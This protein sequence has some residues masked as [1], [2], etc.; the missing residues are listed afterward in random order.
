MLNKGIENVIIINTNLG[1]LPNKKRENFW[2]L[3]I[4]FI[5]SYIIIFINLLAFLLLLLFVFFILLL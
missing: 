5:Q 3:Y 1:S 2:T 4:I